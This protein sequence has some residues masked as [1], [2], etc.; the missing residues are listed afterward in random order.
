MIL[1]VDPSAPDEVVKT[2][3]SYC[4]AAKLD[5]MKKPV[6][7]ISFKG[8]HQIV[9]TIQ[10][11]TTVASRAGW[12]GSDEIV[13]SDETVTIEGK[14]Y[15]K[16]GSQVVYKVVNGVR[17]PFQGPRVYLSERYQSSWGRAG[18]M[19][20]FQKC[21]TAAALRPAFPEELSHAYIEDEIPSHQAMVEV[22]NS[23]IEDIKKQLS[24]SASAASAS[25]SVDA[26]ASTENP[27]RSEVAV[28]NPLEEPT[29]TLE[30]VL[31][32]F[33]ACT[34]KEALEETKNVAKQYINE[35]SEADQETV[36]KAYKARYKVLK[37]AT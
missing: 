4:Q 35:L 22:D 23:A 2:A 26:A 16:W 27:V 21:I 34:T 14:K 28:E 24:S 33:D 29:L 18:I 7:I 8:R 31:E 13:F 10:A 37:G 19:A 1:G 20:M 3:I 36:K 17:C 15:P 11:L 5:P 12:A 32:S 6:A 9:F 30:D 25:T